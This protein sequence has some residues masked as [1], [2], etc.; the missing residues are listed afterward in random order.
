VELCAESEDAD[1]IAYKVVF[2]KRMLLRG[3]VLLLANAHLAEMASREDGK[4]L[5]AV[6]K[7]ADT[8]DAIEWAQNHGG[9]S[10]AVLEAA[11]ILA[12]SQLVGER[13]TDT[14]MWGF[15]AE[16]NTAVEEMLSS[17]EKRTLVVERVQQVWLELMSQN[18]EEWAQEAAKRA[19]SGI[20]DAC[21][22]QASF[23]SLRLIRPD[24]PEVVLRSHL[25]SLT[26]LAT[27]GEHNLKTGVEQVAA[28]FV[29]WFIEREYSALLIVPEAGPTPVGITVEEPAQKE[30][31][32]L[33]SYLE[34]QSTA[35]A[36]YY[37]PYYDRYV[38]DESTASAPYYTPYHDR[39]LTE[40][41]S[42]A[43]S[44]RRRSTLG[45][46]LSR[47]SETLSR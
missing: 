8:I 22:S 24:I 18:G 29:K 31:E 25:R 46:L 30:V 36:P 19:T 42:P 1:L 41:T 15:I 10:V 39:A 34:D 13:S 17:D 26:S 40:S 20:P 16:H 28:L 47:L 44:E 4:M 33:A 27:N 11:K 12:V 3:Q 32:V 37:A 9:E 38:P 6:K 45:S 7:R 35:P 5:N 14:L 43:S 21:E 2:Q 23:E